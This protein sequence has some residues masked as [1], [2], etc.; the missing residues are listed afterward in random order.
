MNPASVTALRDHPGYQPAA[1]PISIEA[2]QAVLGCLLRQNSGIGAVSSFLKA[3]HFSEP[4]HQAIYAAILDRAA[5][6]DAANAITLRGLLPAFDIDG[7]GEARYLAF[8]T[9][10][11]GG[12]TVVDYG[13]AV[14]DLAL[15]RALI[16]A[17]EDIANCGRSPPPGFSAP[18]QAADAEHRLLQIQE[19]F[20]DPR[21]ARR[22]AGFE[23]VLLDIEDRRAS[24]K[25][26]RG[27]QCGLVDLDR[28]LGGFPAGTLVILGARP[29]MGKTLASLS[30][31]RRAAHLGVG[32]AFDSIEMSAEQVALRLLSDEAFA[33][34]KVIPYKNAGEGRVQPEEV[35]ALGRAGRVLHDLPLVVIDQG[36]RLA[37]IPNHIRF[38]RRHLK[39]RGA[40]LA[41]FFIDYLGLISPGD[42]Y[43]GQRVHEVTEISNTLKALAKRENICIVALHQLNRANESRGDKRP[44]LSDLRDSGSL[45]QDADV[46][47]FVHREA[48]YLERTGNSDMADIERHDKFEACKHDIEFIIAKQRQGPIGTITCWC[49]PAVN[50][51]RDKA[52]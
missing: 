25:H 44:I 31:A 4:I 10:E 34:G 2:E 24:G 12:G 46:V 35:A 52:L 8:L 21:Q 23:E 33:Q 39:G 37:D 36:N 9:A 13:R 41:L 18:E 15:R 45:E 51:V 22:E 32:V 47:M 42:R 43:K 20:P 1:M 26:F 11:G 17:G 30:M 7:M 19:Q 50:A 3:E 27:V 5:K 40:D 14:Y 29:S 49:D 6:G 48:Y 38:A 28:R 16:A